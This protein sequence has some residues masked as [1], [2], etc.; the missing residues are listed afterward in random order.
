MRTITVTLPDEIAN[1]VD[2]LVATG[3]WSGVED[4]A[5][6]AMTRHAAY[7]SQ[8][9]RT[10]AELM[11]S[12]EAAIEEADRDGCIDGEA[13]MDEWIAEIEARPDHS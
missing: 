13:F 4:F 7:W 10:E 12:I 3:E 11:A 1:D 8:F 9:P 2:R 6:E 5:S